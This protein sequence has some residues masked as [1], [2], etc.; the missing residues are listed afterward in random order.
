MQNMQTDCEAYITSKNSLHG[1]RT[2]ES[3]PYYD[4]SFVR[5]PQG[6]Y[7]TIRLEKHVFL[8]ILLQYKIHMLALN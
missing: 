8:N 7:Q 4:L 5:R 2:T 3:A 1:P 6:F